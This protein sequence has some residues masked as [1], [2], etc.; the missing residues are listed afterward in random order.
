V[1]IEAIALIAVS[2][3]AFMGAIYFTCKAI[4]H[5][6]NVVTNVTGKYTSFFGPFSL[7]MASQFNSKGNQHRAALGPAILGLAICWAVLFALGVVHA[8]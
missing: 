7:F 1:E 8:A 5:M 6:Y 2:V 4:F 3:L